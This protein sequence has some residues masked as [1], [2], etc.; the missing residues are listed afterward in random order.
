MSRI[1][2]KP[3]QLPAGVEFTKKENVVT[4]KGPLGQLQRELHRLM[5]VELQDDSILV[6]RNSDSKEER[7]L[8]GLTRTLVANMVEGV[9]KGY[10]KTLELVG[11]G[12]RATKQGDT[13]V[14]NIGYSHPV[15]IVPPAGI[16][17]EV[18]LPTKIV[19]K[20]IDKEAVG[21]IAANI[22]AV[23]EPEPYK[24]KGIKYDTERIRRKV[25]KT[26]K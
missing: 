7:S 22:R 14:I 5:N 6:T 9:T 11:V 18:P 15:N 10:S 25:G 12:Y 8:H 21:S 2:R 26:G 3:I 20:G 4:V 13:V 23:R 1:G 24:G 19:V 17:L 16:E